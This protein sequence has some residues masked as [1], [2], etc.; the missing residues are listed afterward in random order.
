MDYSEIYQISF[1]DNPYYIH[2]HI[3]QSYHYFDMLLS[4][5]FCNNDL[6]SKKS[7]NVELP[8]IIN[9]NDIVAFFYHG[10]MILNIDVIDFDLLLKIYN[11][12]SFFQPKDTVVM[13]S[14]IFFYHHHNNYID[15]VNIK[16]IKGSNINNNH[17]IMLISDY[18]NKTSK[19]NLNITWRLYEF[20]IKDIECPN[21]KE[22]FN[23]HNISIEDY[24][25]ELIKMDNIQKGSNYEL[26]IDID[27]KGI[28]SIG[29]YLFLNDMKLDI[30]KY[31]SEYLA[32]LLIQR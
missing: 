13:D 5:K 32:E 28:K 15:K 20:Q 19:Y 25:I 26:K 29:I 4:E 10:S 7:H 6:R 27:N 18:I 16:V 11:I 17:K 9:F 30:T 22:F 3:L 8:Y 14:L 12:L 24:K 23:L 1:N 21:I 2:K 31:L